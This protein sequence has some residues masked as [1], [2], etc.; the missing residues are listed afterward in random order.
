MDMSPS[1]QRKLVDGSR[2]GDVE[3][4]LR[5]YPDI[6]D[7]EAAE[8]LRFL[9]KGPPLEVAL[10]TTHDDV[11]AKLRAFRADHAAEFSLGP[12]EYLIVAAI[13]I[14]LVTVLTLLWDSGLG[15]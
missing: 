9:K 3:H 12:K 13:V 5:R 2:R 4:L 15:H 14:A 1:A 10:L 6:L 8:I 7:G 11:K